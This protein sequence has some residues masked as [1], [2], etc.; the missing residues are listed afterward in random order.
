MD[1]PYTPPTVKTLG[2]V[3]ELTEQ[4]FNKIGP[5]PDGQTN[6]PNIVGSLTPVP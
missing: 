5:T 3:K 6:N 4:N 1:K 2:S